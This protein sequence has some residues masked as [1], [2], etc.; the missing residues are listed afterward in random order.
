MWSLLLLRQATHLHPPLRST[1]LLL[2][3]LLRL[4][5]HLSLLLLETSYQVR[6]FLLHLPISFYILFA[7]GSPSSAEVLPTWAWIVIGVVV[8]VLVLGA[9]GGAVYLLVIRPRQID[10]PD[11]YQKFF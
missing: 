2:L 10:G 4:L 9:I 5:L 7:I 3:L 8:G 6:L 11:R 1:L